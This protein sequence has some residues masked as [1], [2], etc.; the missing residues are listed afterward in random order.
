LHPISF[1]LVVDDFGVKHV[2]K[3]DIDHLID[4]IKKTYTLTKDWTGALYCSVALDWDY[5]NR[6]VDILI[7]GYIKKKLQEYNQVQSKRIQTCPYTPAPK[8]FGTEAQRLL[9]LD[10]SPLLD[11][12]ASSGYNRSWGVFYTMHKQS[13]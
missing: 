6:A 7:P 12:K 1:T 8:Q 5:K 9:L 10:D 3:A 2:D 4:S 11:K 13:I